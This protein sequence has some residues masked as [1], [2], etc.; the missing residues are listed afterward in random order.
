M[1]CRASTVQGDDAVV[2]FLQGEFDL[3]SQAVLGQ[4]LATAE[5]GSGDVVVDLSRV[6]F[7]DGTSLRRLLHSRRELLGAGRRLVVRSPSRPCRLLLE[8]AEVDVDGE[9]GL[10]SPAVRGPVGGA[11]DVG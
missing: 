4:A 11:P 3:S 5:A 2:V 7:M 9:G 8:A 10:S 1:W 6:T